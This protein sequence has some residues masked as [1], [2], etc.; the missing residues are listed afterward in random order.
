M[1]EYIEL[2]S[3]FCSKIDIK[4]ICT[5]DYEAIT[6]STLPLYHKSP[7]FIL[8]KEGKGSIEVDKKRYELRPGGLLSI[9][10]WE[11]TQIVDV[12]GTLSLEII[13]YNYDVVAET[14]KSS[15][16]VT[17]PVSALK[18]L[19]QSSYV[20]LQKEEKKEVEYL[21]LKIRE[22]VGVE[23][24]MD[25]QERRS[26]QE[27]NIIMLISSLIIAFC[28]AM[29]NWEGKTEIKDEREDNRVLILRYIYMYLGEKIT[30]EKVA[31]Q[32]YLSRSSVRMYLYEK[33]GLAFHELVN[34]MRI[35][36]TINYLLYTDMTLEDIAPILGYVDAAHI[37]KVFSYRME[38]KISEYRKTYQKVLS[39]TNIEEK[40]L[41]YQLVEYIS[42]NYREEIQALETAERFGVSV[43]EMNRHL[44]MQ[45]EYNFYDFLNR[46]RIDKACEMLLDTDQSITDIA[47]EVGYGTVKTF[48]RNFIQLRHVLPNEF[49]AAQAR[50]VN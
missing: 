42:R 34:E 19:E 1:K 16:S 33:T 8:V 18:K 46:L 12:R 48:R 32:F 11:C 24:V 22:E 21:F 2:Q 14:L 40:K 44:M 29:D 7:R 36:K 49:R 31:K 4:K 6:E 5:F 30:L 20:S 50:L 15:S 9:L 35:V 38:N 28:R 47:I 41:A 43:E 45:V 3:Q 39:I 23:S 27:M 37:S 26:Y 10:P 25:F 13:K 17:D